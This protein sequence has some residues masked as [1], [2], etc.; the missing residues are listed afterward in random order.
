MIFEVTVVKAELPALANDWTKCFV[1][2]VV[3][4]NDVAKT[5]STKKPGVFEWQEHF[6]LASEADETVY[7]FELRKKSTVSFLGHQLLASTEMSLSEL[8]LRAQ[9][10]SHLGQ[11]MSLP[12]QPSKGKLSGHDGAWNLFVR[13]VVQ[14]VPHVAK[15][16]HPRISHSLS[17]VVAKLEAFMQ[18]GDALAQLHPYAFIAWRTATAVYTILKTQL[19]Q[20]AR[21]D[22]LGSLMKDAYLFVEDIKPFPEK[23]PML[24]ETIRKLLVQTSE[25]IMF[26]Q[27]CSG[28]GFAKRLVSTAWVD[29]RINDFTDSFTSLKRALESGVAVQTTIVS[30]RI[31]ETIKRIVNIQNLMKLNPVDMDDPSRPEC[32]PNT[33]MDVIGD[34]YDWAATPT[35]SNVFWLHGFPGAGK[36]TIATS[37]AN[38]FRQQRRLGAFTFFTRGVEARSDPASLIRTIA[39][40]LGEFD[41]RICDAISQVIEETPS[42]KQAPLHWQFQRLL[43]DPFRSLEDIQHEGPVLVVIDALDEC[44]RTGARNDLLTALVRESM[45]LP[46][47]LRIFITSRTEKDIH[48]AISTHSHIISRELDLASETNE[49]DVKTYIHHKMVA[50]RL[51]NEYL[52]LPP[53]WPG[54]SRVDALTLRASG[55]FVW[56]AT[57]CR[58]VENAQDPEERLSQLLRS[59][60]Q[61][62]SESAL[63]NIYITALE[64]AGKW[65]DSAFAA[66]FQEILG[67]VIV[68]ENPLTPPTIDIL[69]ADFTGGRKKRPCLHTIQHLSCLLQWAADKPVR[70]FHPSFADFI[71]ERRRCGR[72]AWHINKSHHHLRLA[73]QCIARLAVALQKNICQITLSRSFEVQNLPDATAYPC[74]HWIDHLCEVQRSEHSLSREIDGFLRQHFLHWVEAMS[75]I[76]RPRQT[77]TLMDKLR[78]WVDANYN[79][80]DSLRSFV[81]DAERFC[82]AYAHVFERHPLLVYQSALPFTPTSS[83]IY[84]TFNEPTLP[85]VDGFRDQWSPL[86]TEFSKPGE[87]VTSVSCSKDGRYIV[88]S[89]T[90]SISLWDHTSYELVTTMLPGARNTTNVVKFSRDSQHIAS[91]H[92]DGSVRLWDALS[93]E[94][95]LPTMKGHGGSVYAL[96][97]SEDGT[98]LVS[99]GQ[100]KN[101][102]L[103]DVR[104]GEMHREPLSGHT[105]T[106]LC[107]CFAH[108]GTRFASGSRDRFIRIWDAGTGKEVLPPILYH[109]GAVN[110]LVYT[111]DGRRLISASDDKVICVWDANSGTLQRLPGTL[112]VPFILRGHSSAIYSLS[113]SPDSTL[114]VSASRDTTARLWDIQAGME[115]PALVRQHRLPVRC[116][117]F[118]AD[119]RRI[120]T[121]S[122]NDPILRLWDTESTG[123]MGIT[124]R[125]KGLVGYVSFSSD[126]QR[127]V[128]GGKD[129]RVRVW[130][131]ETGAM[132][133]ELF[134]EREVYRVGFSTDGSKILA[135]DDARAVF[136]WKSDTH[137]P[138][139]ATP[140]DAPRLEGYR[141]PLSIIRNQWIVNA[142]TEEVLLMFP[143]MSPIMAKASCGHR[144]AVGTANGGVVIVRFHGVEAERKL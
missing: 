114:L 39:Y 19:G 49:R 101:I 67:I 37:V 7:R 93:G 141:G 72:D 55:L 27:E 84:K 127:L 38:L 59:E 85:Q 97:F 21:L 14:D 31:D 22:A 12:L 87:D 86:L 135:L 60:V 116:A 20:D 105:K 30:F 36:S 139:M 80:D 62:D 43:A 74:T 143:N 94:E 99:A 138:L 88:S 71:T 104:T 140:G 69:N 24:E 98:Q 122:F 50:I 131:A 6:V 95:I 128:S 57:A 42:I 102:V 125:H 13:L 133:A 108:S 79:H 65:N 83:V 89:G 58:Y 132:T 73:R 8:L 115:L 47:T 112:N 68:A 25:C 96:D 77:I 103:W 123:S 11:N 33:R 17:E 18:L 64:S 45:L 23:I 44:G 136:A 56:A 53:D 54:A 29:R 32:L 1:L 130:D 66:D 70:V 16:E 100:D 110:A 76:G 107:L 75:A 26:V 120:V 142:R 92:M 144:F 90:R 61:A 2:I 41:P 118:T 82:Q 117:T 121:S 51:Q 63:D 81:K 106:V 40:Q 109:A 4:G 5:K 10:A 52:D 48:S 129:C 119:G 78:E 91:G 3:D 134:L 126:G 34:I 28:H 46:P 137:E 9:K 35:R 113:I 111:P 124:R 15:V